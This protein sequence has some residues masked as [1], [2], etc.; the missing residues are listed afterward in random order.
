MY[1]LQNNMKAKRVFFFG[2]PCVIAP[3]FLLW[4]EVDRIK[5]WYSPGFQR[6]ITKM[7]KQLAKDSH[8]TET[9]KNL[10]LFVLDNSLRETTV[11][12]L[13]GHTLENKLKIYDQV[14]T[15]LRG[16]EL[17]DQ[18]GQNVIMHVTFYEKVTPL[19]ARFCNNLVN[20]DQR[21]KRVS[22]TQ[23]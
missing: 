9:L 6:Q 18:R 22:S 10:D 8:R 21:R 17:L 14:S 19:A 5:A 4:H 15:F 3:I 2:G 1:F 23:N 11:G 16:R 7:R 13:R 12:Q 20:H